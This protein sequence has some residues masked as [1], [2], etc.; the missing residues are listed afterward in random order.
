MSEYTKVEKEVSTY[1]KV[2]KEESQETRE[3]TWK[4][5]GDSTQ[6]DIADKTW[7]DWYFGLISMWTKIIKEISTYKKV[8]K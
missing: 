7:K 6:L 1:T 5:L 4:D 8:N 3:M 2:N